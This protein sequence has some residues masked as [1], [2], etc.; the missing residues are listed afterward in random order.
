LCFLIRD[1]LSAIRLRL[2]S[3][4]YAFVI[5]PEDQARLKIMSPITDL[6]QCVQSLG[7]RDLELQK[8]I[9]ADSVKISFSSKVP[10]TNSAAATAKVALVAARTDLEHIVYTD[11]TAAVYQEWNVTKKNKFGRKQERVLG[12][13]GKKVYNS[14][15]DKYSRSAQG[16]HRAQRYI[17]SIRKVEILDNDRKTLRITWEDER[18]VYDIEYTCDTKRDCVEIAAKILFLISP[19]TRK[20]NNAR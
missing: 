16:V 9:Y 10:G 3:D 13:D 12:V 2:F 1:L 5:S 11:T 15:R 4:E 8:R 19:S 17:S 6:N 7:V 20:S 18:E 14:K